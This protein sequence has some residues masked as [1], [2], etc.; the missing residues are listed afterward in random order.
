MVSFWVSHLAGAAPHLIYSSLLERVAD[1]GCTVI[2]T[3]YN[4]TFSHQ[5]CAE[6]VH[7]M[8]I[9]SLQK[10]RSSQKTAWVAPLE[11]DVHGMGHSNGAL[12]LTL[13]GCLRPSTYASNVL[14]SFN[15]RQ[16]KE[17]IPLPLTPLQAAAFSGKLLVGGSL[18][19]AS[20]SLA[21]VAVTMADAF[22]LL[23]SGSSASKSV[24]QEGDDNDRDSAFSER[25]RQVFPLFTQLGG[26]FDEMANG[27]LDFEPAPEVNRSLLQARYSVPRNL[28]VRF[29][30]DSIDETSILAELLAN[31]QTAGITVEVLG[32]K[33]THLTPVA[34]SVTVASSGRDFA[35]SDALAQGLVAL[36]Q[37]ELNVMT[38]RIISWLNS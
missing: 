7:E 37:R 36:S 11:C 9:E 22:D 13:I 10:L 20:R 3:P 1:A 8:F 32:L 27:R 31:R 16:V 18:L 19:D 29:D 5:S 2:S 28:L 38:R 15:N 14:I 35:P 25:L 33:G 34:P 21:D 12:L 24:V 30:N 17:A 4:V 23:G 26:V 6:A